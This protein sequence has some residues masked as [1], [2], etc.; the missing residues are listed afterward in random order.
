MNSSDIAQELSHYRWLALGI[1]ELL[2]YKIFK[3]CLELSF[4][5]INGNGRVKPRI[6]HVSLYGVDPGDMNCY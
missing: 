6:Q 1:E 5:Y 3:G 2:E 4:T